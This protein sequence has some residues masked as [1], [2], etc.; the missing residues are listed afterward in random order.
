MGETYSG[1]LWII[2]GR[3]FIDNNNMLS[4]MTLYRPSPAHHPLPARSLPT[5]RP[6]IALLACS[7]PAVLPKYSSQCPVHLEFGMGIP[8]VRIS[9]T[10]PIMGTGTYHTV[11]CTVS[12]KTC[13]IP[14]THSILI[15]KITII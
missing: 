2:Y 1:S 7:A 14:L 11:I 5:T 12:H 15:I 4:I 10:I 6:P 13:S 3:V 8:W 9:H